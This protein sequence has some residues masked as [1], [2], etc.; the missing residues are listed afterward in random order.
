MSDQPVGPSGEHPV[1][2]RMLPFA[3]RDAEIRDRYLRGETLG[4]IGKAFGLSAERIRKIVKRYGLDKKNAG[5][6]IRNNRRP[7]VPQ[8]A[9]QS[10]RVYG[11]AAAQLVA[12]SQEQRQAYLQHR[13]NARRSQGIDWTLTLAQWVDIWERSG[14]WAE[15][16]QGPL[17]YGLAR[18]DVAGAFSAEN[19]RVARNHDSAMRGRELKSAANQ[20]EALRKSRSKNWIR[21]MARILKKSSP[22]EDLRTKVSDQQ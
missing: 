3:G 16:G 5:L 12:F 20:R 22:Q 19:V 21:E 4:S 15:R 8:K 7:R 14:K 1:E 11:C 9:P 13:T 17:K 2:N 6:A 10:L 18:V